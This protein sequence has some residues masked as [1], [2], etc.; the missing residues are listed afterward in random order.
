MGQLTDI[1]ALTNYKF[2]LIAKF[3]ILQ[4]VVIV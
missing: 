1:I 2:F 4:L 3:Y